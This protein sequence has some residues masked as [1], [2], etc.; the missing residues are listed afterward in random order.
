MST[1]SVEQQPRI[2]RASSRDARRLAAFASRMFRL[3]FESQNTPEDMAAHVASAF[4]EAL[5]RSEID[6]PN[7]ITLLAEQRD[8]LV[9]YAQLRA[10]EPP[11]C[12]SD[13]G[14]LEL[15]RFYVD[16][17]LH[18]RGFAHALMRETL[19]VASSRARSIWL[20]VWERNA[21]AIAFYEKWGF[22]DVGQHQFVLG[23]DRQ[24]DRIMWRALG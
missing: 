3:T 18:G 1:D 10:G 4:S 8:T 11:G 16:P 17:T 13:R 2:F 12:V 7:G 5:Q 20:G 15:M 6:D 22:V 24:I 23:T 14:A 9:G 19:A 21:R